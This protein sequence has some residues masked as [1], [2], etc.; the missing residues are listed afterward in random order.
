MAR[1]N[2]STNSPYYTMYADAR[3]TSY[4]QENNTSTVVVDVYMQR[5]VGSYPENGGAYSGSITVDNQTQNYSDRL[6]Y[7]TSYS[8]GESRLYA[9]LTF[10][11][12]PHNTDGSKIVTITGTY[13]AGFSPT[14]GSIS[15]SLELTTIPRESTATATDS[16]IGTPTHIS[17]T[18][19]NENYTHSIQ[20][21]FGTQSGYITSA[22][23]TTSSTETKINALGIDFQLPTAWYQEI[24]NDPYGICTLTIKTYSGDT[25]IGSAKTT[26]FRAIVN[27]S[28]NSPVVTATVRDTNGVT[29]SLARV[30]TYLIKGYATAEVTWSATPQH[31]AT[32]SQVTIDDEVVTTSPFSKTF[33]G[34]LLKVKA[35]DSRGL[36]TERSPS[37]TLVD[38]FKPTATI[39][40]AERVSPTSGSINVSFDGTWF[41][42]R[43]GP[44]TS[45]GQ[46]NTLEIKWYYRQYGG[47]SWTL[48]GTLTENTDY[49]INNNTFWSGSSTSAQNITIGNNSLD[50]NNAWDIKLVFEDKLDQLEMVLEITKGIPIVNWGNDFFNVNGDIKYHNNSIVHY[51]AN[52]TVIGKWTDDKPIYR[53]IITISSLPSANSSQTYQSGISNM[54]TLV[55]MDGIYTAG[56]SGDYVKF[57]INHYFPGAGTDRNISTRYSVANSGVVITVGDYNFSSYSGFV[58]LEYT[59]STD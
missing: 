56:Q 20:Y 5:T 15:G 32:L 7:P 29:Q 58:I 39:T 35:T 47:S 33:T 1:I 12:I 37:F 53:K 46:V 59:K 8:E 28:T 57:P 54:D 45:G 22:S 14:E 18:R 55:R 44:A 48:G 43:F 24:P 31:S 17:V 4:S 2:G 26:T 38:Y 6:P 34:T 27:P 16:Y 23:G 3:E 51:K 19:R 25:Q 30:N 42:D 9:T 40:T 11:N 41:N 10:T 49:K 50:Y 13:S 21:S 36:Y 52:E